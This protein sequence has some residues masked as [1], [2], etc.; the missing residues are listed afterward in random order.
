[1][2]AKWIK[3][4]KKTLHNKNSISFFQ[5]NFLLSL[6]PKKWWSFGYFFFAASE[7]LKIFW[8]PQKRLKFWILDLWVCLKKVGLGSGLYG[9]SVLYLMIPFG[10][11][12]WK[13]IQQIVCDGIKDCVI[14]WRRRP[15]KYIALN[16]NM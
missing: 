13:G 10:F 6:F 3:F 1:M 8:G 4:F 15:W 5:R 11:I 9:K 12:Y 2:K 16:D 7:A 14:W